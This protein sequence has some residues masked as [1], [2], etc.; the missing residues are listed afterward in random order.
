LPRPNPSMDRIAPQN[1]ER[2]NGR[3][4]TRAKATAMEELTE[5][6][7][8]H[9]LH[10]SWLPQLID[11]WIDGTETAGDW[12]WSSFTSEFAV[13]IDGLARR[14]DR[15]ERKGAEEAKKPEQRRAEWTAQQARYKPDPALEAK[16]AERAAAKR[17]QDEEFR[18]GRLE[19]A[20]KRRER[21][22][23][24]AAR[25]GISMD[26][27]HEYR[28]EADRRGITLD[29]LVSEHFELAAEWRSAALPW[30]D[31]S[32]MSRPCNERERATRPVTTTRQCP[33]PITPS[34]SFGA[35]LA[36]ALARW[37]PR[38]AVA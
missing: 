22:K 17:K 16:H 13:S 29:E 27:F 38:A 6:C 30:P 3:R 7:E 2:A 36:D 15:Q 12:A 20:A 1:S 26:D 32:G 28:Y 18:Q 24:E 37:E 23:A 10:P 33:A 14:L 4:P 25:L 9:K 31:R 34:R 11:W 35:V 5:L 19:R 21:D 8:Q